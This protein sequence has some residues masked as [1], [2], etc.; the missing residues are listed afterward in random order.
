MA[1]AGPRPAD[2]EPKRGGILKFVVPDEPP[3]FDGHKE[4][5]FALIHPIAPFYSVL[6]RVDPNNPATL[7]DYVCDLCTEMPSATDDGKSY[8]FKIRKGVT[9]HDGSKLS[10]KDVLASY[11]RI[12]F[13]PEGVSSARK[14][15]YPMV[16]SVTSPDDD[17]IVFKLKYPSGAFIPSLANPYNFI[18]S[19]AKLDADQKWYET[20]VMGSGPFIFEKREAGR[21][22]CRQA[23]PELLS[24]GAALPR[25]LRVD[26]RQEAV[27]ARAGHSWRSGGHRIPLLPAEE[28]R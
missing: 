3:S 8:T 7:T 10:A 19:K 9:F 13:P 4:T 28:P 1:L 17:T 12:I 26:L 22:H 20:N 16:A 24:Q 27:A 14:S 11:Q 21:A 23:Q 25:W 18:Y 15:Q 2:A 6:I 5:T